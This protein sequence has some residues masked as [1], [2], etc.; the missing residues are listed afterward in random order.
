MKKLGFTQN[1]TFQD[2]FNSNVSKVFI[3]HYWNTLIKT[4]QLALFTIEKSAKDL[5]RE[6]C[7]GDPSLKPKQAIYQVGLILL[8]KDNNGLTELRSIFDGHT[9]DRNW[10]RT[11]D[12]FKQ[13]SANTVPQQIRGWVNQ[14]EKQIR[15]YKPIN[16]IK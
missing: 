14:I 13:I 15:V 8:A 4:N 11:K 9:N 12:D 1:P 3:G 5:L 10:Y 7:R 2:I 6:M 16:I